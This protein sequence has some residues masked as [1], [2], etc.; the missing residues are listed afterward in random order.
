[1]EVAMLIARHRYRELARGEAIR[2]GDIEADRRGLDVRFIPDGLVILRRTRFAGDVHR[3]LDQ[4]EVVRDGDQWWDPSGRWRPVWS[5]I[6]AIV[7]NERH[8]RRRLDDQVESIADIRPRTVSA[9][10]RAREIR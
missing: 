4:G 9:M 5:A 3:F 10:D 8:V 7:V 2:A 1:M 6:G